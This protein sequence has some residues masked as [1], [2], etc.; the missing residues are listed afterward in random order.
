M[1][2]QEGDRRKRADLYLC[3]RRKSKDPLNHPA[4]SLAHPPAR[5]LDT[6][7]QQLTL[8]Y[9]LGLLRVK[10]AASVFVT[11]S[12][13]WPPPGPC[14]SI[15]PP[16]GVTTT[17]EEQRPGGEL[18]WMRRRQSFLIGR[19]RQTRHLQPTEVRAAPPR[20]KT[21]K[22]KN[23]CIRVRREARLLAGSPPP[24]TKC[25]TF[26][27]DLRKSLNQKQRSLEVALKCVLRTSGTIARRIKGSVPSFK[28]KHFGRCQLRFPQ[29]NRSLCTFHI[30][31]N[32]PE[33][34]FSF[35]KG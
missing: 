21:F 30:Q 16:C 20:Q 9:G 23:P 11:S 13:C 17:Y 28:R 29:Y 27:F 25:C 4:S 14:E 6:I 12:C 32:W 24:W 8:I 26:G 22:K 1:E 33:F 5:C 19:F 15:H 31:R 2:R 3:A 18:W 7:E 10:A 35:W 34:R